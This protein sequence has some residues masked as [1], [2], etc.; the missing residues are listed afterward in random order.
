MVQQPDYGFLPAEAEAADYNL[1]ICYSYGIT[2]TTTGPP[3]KINRGTSRSL[4]RSFSA[5]SM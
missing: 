5:Y 3:M 1:A 4:T 2:T